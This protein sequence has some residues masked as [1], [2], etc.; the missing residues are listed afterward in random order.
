[1]LQAATIASFLHRRSG[2]KRE[3]TETTSVSG[4]FSYFL[5]PSPVEA[6]VG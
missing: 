2:T 5:E 3:G 6:A 1:V 4:G